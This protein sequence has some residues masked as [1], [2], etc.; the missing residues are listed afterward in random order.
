MSRILQIGS[1]LLLVAGVSYGS[2]QTPNDS[3]QPSRPAPAKP[4]PGKGGAPKQQPIPKG[5]ARLLNPVSVAARLF[6][7]SPEEREHALEKLPTEQGRENARKLLNWFDSLPR[8]TQEI[9]LRRLDHFA[10]LT[11]EQRAEV[12][13]LILEANHLPPGRSAAVGQALF[14]LQRMTDQEREATLQRPAFQARFSPEE[15][16]I[17]SRLSDAWMGPVQ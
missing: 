8:E 11:P 13:G 5:G 16:R 14:R 3:P 17:I 2:S 4:A 7:M 6:R 1:I 9:Q 12:R 15:L 10:Q